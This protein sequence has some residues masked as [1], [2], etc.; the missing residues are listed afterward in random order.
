MPL[1]LQAIYPAALELVKL[2]Y[3]G[4]PHLLLPKRQRSRSDR[5]E[6]PYA[7]LA[8]A[9]LA[10]LKLCYGL[11]GRARERLP[12]LPPPPQW[13]QWAERVIAQLPGALSVA[14]LSLLMRSTPYC[15]ELT[16]AI[17]GDLARMVIVTWQSSIF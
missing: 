4:T 7:R 5:S 16:C 10:T 2:H 6:N 11:D 3:E 14:L 15:V 12:G 17:F 13:H 8:A 1:I 9:L